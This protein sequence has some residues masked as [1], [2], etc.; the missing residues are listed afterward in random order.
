MKFLKQKTTIAALINAVLATIFLVQYLH[1]KIT[2]IE[3][4]SAIAVAG[5]I[6]ASIIGL[7]APDQPVT[8]KPKDE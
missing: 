8:P 2:L 4:T 7:A 1:A 6:S 3:F 5:S